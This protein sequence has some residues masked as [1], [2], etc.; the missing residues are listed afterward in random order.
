[1][2]MPDDDDDLGEGYACEQCRPQDHQ[3]TV[4]AIAQGIKIW[5]T[6]N[7]IW[8]NEKKAG[9]NRKGK[10]QPGWLKKDVPSSQDTAESSEQAAGSK[11]KRDAE[12]GSA[13]AEEQQD[14]VK[15]EQEEDEK[16]T[17][18][19]N[20]QDKRRKSAGPSSMDPETEI[21]PVEQ[22]PSDRQKIV[23]VLSKII[24]D[25]INVRSKAGAYRIPDG[26]T[27]KSLGEH[28]A[29]RTNTL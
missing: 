2:G 16:P 12:V 18:L 28:Y 10:K 19:S 9:R 5:E 24:A 3:E 20:R 15:E 21:V 6:R 4:Q 7:K 14:A 22:L 26:H 8:A 29:L 27:P 13:H 1:M 25:D 23:T 11:R 17:R